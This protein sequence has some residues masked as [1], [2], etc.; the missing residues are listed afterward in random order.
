[1]SHRKTRTRDVN[2]ED[3]RVHEL[4]DIIA[5]EVSDVDRAANRRRYLAIKRENDGDEDGLGPEIFD[6]E[7]MDSDPEDASLAKA[8]RSRAGEDDE[9]SEDEE[10]ADVF[11]G[12]EASEDEEESDEEDE[13]D[14][15]AEPPAHA[16]GCTAPGHAGQSR[17]APT[18][19]PEGLRRAP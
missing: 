3:D 13:D 1:M 15:E 2:N 10:L 9:E 12:D 17:W 18:R 7:D 4:V 6:D 5:E 8:R 16:E 14:E 19:G 11:E